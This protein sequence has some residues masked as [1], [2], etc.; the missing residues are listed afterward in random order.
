MQVKWV[1]TVY[2]KQKKKKQTQNKLPLQKDV[3]LLYGTC[4]L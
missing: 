3:P 1:D 4:Q 2:E